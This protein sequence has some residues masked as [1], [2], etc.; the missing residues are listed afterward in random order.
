MPP[1]PEQ[2]LKRTAAISW[3]SVR[4]IG[5]IKA[6]KR[7]PEEDERVLRKYIEE[8]YDQMHELVSA[9]RGGKL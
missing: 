9:E 7:L 4:L 3:F 6:A 1:T 5:R 2:E 8:F